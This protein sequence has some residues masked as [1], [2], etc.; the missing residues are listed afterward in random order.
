MNKSKV[1]IRV[2]GDVHGC[3]AHRGRGRCYLNLVGKAEYSVQLGDLSFTYTALTNIDS[4]HHRVL[5]GNHEH[6]EKMQDYPHFLGDYGTHSFPLAEGEFKFFFVRGGFSIDRA[7]RTLRIDWFPEEELNFLESQEALKAYQEEKPKIVMSHECPEEIIPFVTTN[8]WNILPSRTAKLL[9]AMYEF[10]RPD[11]WFFG[12]HHRNFRLDYNGR[13][14]TPRG[15]EIDNGLRKP[16][17]F[18]C[19]DELGYM[20]I[21]DHGNPVTYLPQ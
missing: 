8:D 19:L 15:K 10:H 4:T 13:G 9:Q 18:I 17:S 7:Y 1:W 21:D 20:D 6:Y 5:A 12:H 16:T 11:W 14:V 3:V 2:L